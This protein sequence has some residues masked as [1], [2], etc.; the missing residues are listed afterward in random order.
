M[1]F[2]SLR[3]SGQV[4]ILSLQVKDTQKS[5]KNNLHNFLWKQKDF[6]NYFKER[7]FCSRKYIIAIQQDACTDRVRNTFFEKTWSKK[8]RRIYWEEEKRADAAEN[9]IVSSSCV[10]ERAKDFGLIYYSS[11]CLLSLSYRL[12]CTVE[13]VLMQKTD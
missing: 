12:K 1:S 5:S 10:Y 8:I 9:E 11:A 3:R 13:Y 4:I 7:S 2:N 6:K